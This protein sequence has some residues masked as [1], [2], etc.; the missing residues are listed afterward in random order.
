[1]FTLNQRTFKETKMVDMAK[2]VTLVANQAVAEMTKH[3][4]EKYNGAGFVPMVRLDFGFHR[5]TSWGGTK[6]GGIPFVSLAVRKYLA[7]AVSSGMDWN[8]I[9]YKNFQNDPVI[10]SLKNVTWQEA[11]RCLVAHELAHAAQ[12]FKPVTIAAKAAFGMSGMDGA[13]KDAKGHN[14]LWR[15]IYS[16]LRITFI[17]GKVAPPVAEVKLPVVK[18]ITRVYTIKDRDTRIMRPAT[19]KQVWTPEYLKLKG[20]NHAEFCAKHGKE[21]VY[22]DLSWMTVEEFELVYDIA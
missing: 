11:V 3:I 6:R 8:F 13:S 10:G 16:D 5:T 18:L 7:G 12:Y 22:K 9:E 19:G 2:Q 20:I 4:A 1:M 17:N 15:K 21:Q 14:V